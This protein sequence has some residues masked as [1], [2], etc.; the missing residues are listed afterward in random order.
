MNHFFVARDTKR[1]WFCVWGATPS[2]GAR[3]IAQP[4]PIATQGEGVTAASSYGIAVEPHGSAT[5]T[6]VIAGSTT[7]SEEAVNAYRYLSRH[8]A[9]LDAKNV[10]HYA[11]LINRARVRIPDQRLQEVYNWSRIN[12]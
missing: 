11:S 9:T 8:S 7:N 12:M 5:L 3:A 10:A 1:S 6:F 2:G 4:T